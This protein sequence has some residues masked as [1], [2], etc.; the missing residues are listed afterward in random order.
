MTA[1]AIITQTFANIGITVTDALRTQY[2]DVLLSGINDGYLELG[3]KRFL[4]FIYGETKALDADKQL[5]TST[6][7]KTLE[8]ILYIGQYQDGV[9]D[10][11]YGA[12]IHYHWMD[13]DDG[14]TIIVYDAEISQSV[15]ICYRYTPASLVNPAPTTGVGA[16]SP[17]VLPAQYHGLLAHKASAAYWR[18]LNNYERVD[19]F[20]RMY[21]TEISKIY[22]QG[23]SMPDRIRDAFGGAML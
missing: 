8:S 6:L 18:S 12:A 17:E 15:Y 4:N 5:D 13:A 23:M 3:A 22:P 14:K 11:N 9:E 16:T 19:E 21:Y 10:A 20:E 1:Y 7:A 2:N